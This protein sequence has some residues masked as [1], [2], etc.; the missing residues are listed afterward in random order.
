MR[1]FSG[2]KFAKSHTSVIEHAVIVVKIAQRMS[3]ISKIILGEIKQCG[4]GKIH[5]DIKEIQAGI[6]VVVRGPRTVQR[7]TLITGDKKGTKKE[8]QKKIGIT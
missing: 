8:L 1:H 3:W 7:I 2:S 4:S 6:Q 5:Y